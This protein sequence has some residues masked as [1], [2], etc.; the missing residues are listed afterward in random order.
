MMN[1]SKITT[2]PR[3]IYKEGLY[4]IWETP[5][6]DIVEHFRFI[7]LGGNVLL[8][9]RIGKIGCVYQT[10]KDH[11]S[12]QNLFS[13]KNVSGKISLNK[14]VS[15][16]GASP[17][18]KYHYWF[19]KRNAEELEEILPKSIITAIKKIAPDIYPNGKGVAK[20]Y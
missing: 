13:S 4:E 3:R 18:A 10:T 20:F 7:T 19:D 14:L 1:T 6:E 8:M 12:S 5:N 15:L 9:G 11:K 16:W 2:T 17:R